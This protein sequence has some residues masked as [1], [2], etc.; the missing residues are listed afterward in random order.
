[1][2]RSIDGNERTPTA[3]PPAGLLPVRFLANREAPGWAEGGKSTTLRRPGGRPEEAI[4]LLEQQL[5]DALRQDGYKWEPD[6]PDVARGKAIKV[7]L[8][9]HMQRGER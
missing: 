3:D 6:K 4:P 5:A 1:M 2:T 8:A 7:M 9:A